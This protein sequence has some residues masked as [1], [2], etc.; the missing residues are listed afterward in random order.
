MEEEKL[1]RK[2]V[3]ELESGMEMTH[4]TNTTHVAGTNGTQAGLL[5][6]RTNTSM[7]TADN[8]YTYADMMEEEIKDDGNNRPH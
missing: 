1:Q 7:V 5:K 6:G 8:A 4:M 3:E 2:E